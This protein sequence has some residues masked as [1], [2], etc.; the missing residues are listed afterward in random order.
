MSN[1]K[2]QNS[3]P[4]S[5]GAFASRR[6]VHPSQISRWIAEGMPVRDDGRIDSVLAEIWLA[7]NKPSRGRNESFTE[8]HRRAAIAK[9]DVAEMEAAEKRNELVSLTDTKLLWAELGAAIQN[10]IM[11]VPDR[12]AVPLSRM[13]NPREIRMLLMKELTRALSVLSKSPVPSLTDAKR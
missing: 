7:E 13:N 4:L 6:G 1:V 9:A 2:L 11:Q 8:A 5:K 3:K 12:L 10:G